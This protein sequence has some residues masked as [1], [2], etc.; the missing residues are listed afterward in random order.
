MADLIFPP[1]R[2]CLWTED[3]AIVF[4]PAV[5]SRAFGDGRALFSLT[6]INNRPAYWV[7]QGCST[8]QT[9]GDIYAPDDAPLFIDFVDEIVES[10]EDQFGTVR[11][12]ERNCR[13]DWID[14]ETKRFLPRSFTEFP[15]INDENGCAWGR[16]DWPSEFETVT[17][18]WARCTI[19]ASNVRADQLSGRDG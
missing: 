17:H 8:W 7:I 15:T 16:L 5:L 19:L 18:P 6:T 4:T 13:G 1:E 10:V 2:R 12:Y 3:D 9:G 11:G 14:H